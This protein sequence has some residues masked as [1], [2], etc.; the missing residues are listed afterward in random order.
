MTAVQKITSAETSV[1]RNRLPAV[2][3]MVDWNPRTRNLDYGGGKFDNATL[4]LAENF[5][6][7]NLILDPYNRSPQHNGMVRN[8]V[9]R[10]GV[11]SVTL[12]NV[13]N[14]IQ[15]S[16]V[17]IEVL[18]D[19]KAMIDP[20][21]LVPVYI[22]VYEG[23]RTY[24]GRETTKGWQ[25]NTPTKWYLYEIRKVFPY[26]IRKGKL[27]IANVSRETYEMAPQLIY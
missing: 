22:T 6:V 10:F 16:Y 9:D 27:I 21:V 26:T 20:S 1:N 18:K 5:Q 7:H 3:R 11:D 8:Q 23:D 24:R 19:I 17:R 13:L 14:V 2:F 15:E 4:W 12:S 25:N